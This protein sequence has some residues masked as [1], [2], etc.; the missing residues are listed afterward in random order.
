MPEAKFQV[1]PPAT[2]RAS[3]VSESETF[4]TEMES[5]GDMDMTLTRG[6]NSR[7]NHHDVDDLIRTTVTETKVRIS[8]LD[9]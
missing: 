5:V 1:H 8:D 7:L 9:N 3:S 4:F 6:Q 2:Q